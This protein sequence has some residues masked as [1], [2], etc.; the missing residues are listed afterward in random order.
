MAGV[1]EQA[2]NTGRRVPMVRSNTP[3][4]TPFTPHPAYRVALDTPPRVITHSL[5]Q[6]SGWP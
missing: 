2:G 5:F 3:H 4:S 1:Q 6:Q